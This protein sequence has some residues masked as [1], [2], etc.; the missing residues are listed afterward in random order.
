[1]DAPAFKRR[2]SAG[3]GQRRRRRRLVCAIRAAE[4]TFE[5]CTSARGPHQAR[6]TRE[7]AVRNA[8]PPEGRPPAP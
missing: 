1:M 4:F 2:G 5:M 8:F 3:A 6:K 7:A